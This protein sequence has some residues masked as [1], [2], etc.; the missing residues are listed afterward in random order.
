MKAGAL[1]FLTKPV[2]DTDLLEAI[3]RAEARDAA[4]RE[5]Y[6]ELELIQAKS[7]DPDSA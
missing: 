2:N 5:L 7:C 1:D 6:S 3:A 4:S